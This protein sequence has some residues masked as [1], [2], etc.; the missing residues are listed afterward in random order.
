VLGTRNV[1]SAAVAAGAHCIVNISTDKA[2]QP[3]SVLGA[4]K[5]LAEYVA[6]SYACA[7]TRVASVRFGNVL[8]SRGSFLPTLMW[9]VANGAPITIT[10][11]AVTRFFMTIPEASNLVVEAATM[12]TAGETYV[13]DMGEPVRIVDLMS[14]YLDMVGA[15]SEVVFTGLREGEK[16]H[17]ELVD[18]HEL[19]AP[20]QHSKVSRI[21]KRTRCVSTVD[22]DIDLLCESAHTTHPEILRSALWN[23]CAAADQPVPVEEAA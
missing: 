13:L 8:G 11:P 10:D 5:R 6:A 19:S 9:Q 16:L 4:T 2:A 1:V 14:R 7:H 15:S 21:S 18:D 23:L 12:A 3:T 20:T 17:E 22:A